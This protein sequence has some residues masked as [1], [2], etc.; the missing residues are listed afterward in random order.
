MADRKP[1]IFRDWRRD[2]LADREEEDRSKPLPQENLSGEEN[3]PNGRSEIPPQFLEILSEETEQKEE[4]QSE[5]HRSQEKSEGKTQPQKF[6]KEDENRQGNQEDNRKGEDS[7]RLFDEAKS[8][9]ESEGDN[10]NKITADGEGEKETGKEME[11]ETHFQQS[12]NEDDGKQQSP[13]GFPQQP[14]E[15][16]S[17]PERSETTNPLKEEELGGENVQEFEEGQDD[18]EDQGDFREQFE[19]ESGNP[20]ENQGETDKSDTQNFENKREEAN[21]NEWDGNPIEEE[22]ERLEGENWENDGGESGES[23]EEGEDWEDEDGYYDYEEEDFD[24][25]DFDDDFDDEEDFEFSNKNSHM[26]FRPEDTTPIRDRKLKYAVN[27]LFERIAEELSYESEEGQ[28]K[29]DAKKLLKRSID[30]SIPLA[31]CKTSKKKEKIVL[32]LDTSG[33]CKEQAGFYSQVAKVGADRDDVEIFLAPNGVLEYKYEN[34]RWRPVGEEDMLPEA[35]MN[36]EGGNENWNNFFKN[37]TIVFFGDYDAGDSVVEASWNNNVWWF[38]SEGITPRWDADHGIEN[39]LGY[40][41]LREH[42]WCHYGWEDFEGI[43]LESGTPEEFLKNLKLLLKHIH[44]PK[45]LRENL[46]CPQE[47]MQFLPKKNKRKLLR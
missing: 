6:D 31:K 14:I 19:E 1:R 32:I 47:M 34:G 24:D 12:R 5:E 13:E 3:N 18:G 41:D 27:L 33:S 40:L 17:Q 29:W 16:T 30:K 7:K 43:Y 44:N 15:E 9:Q 42:S 35:R 21:G 25:D 22:D 45:K 10:D 28:V 39:R 38:S 4:S 46:C 23:E 26:A 37:R 8:S 20:N 2:F 11:E 36:P